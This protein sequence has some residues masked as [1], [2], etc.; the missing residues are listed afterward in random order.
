[1]ATM[2]PLRQKASAWT[3]GGSP[4]FGAS[5]GYDSGEEGHIHLNDPSGSNVGFWYMMFGGGVSDVVFKI[6]FALAAAPSSA[7]SSGNVYV[8]KSFGDGDLTRDDLRGMFVARKV[9][10]GMLWGGGSATI[11]LAGIKSVASRIDTAFRQFYP[12]L[13]TWRQIYGMISGDDPLDDTNGVRAN[14]VI[15]MAGMKTAMA[16]GAGGAQYVGWLR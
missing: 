8:T 2:I 14:A 7:L 1:M 9:S 6:P 10:G 3:L 4:S 12:P 13:D 16:W 5:V 15:V 11:I